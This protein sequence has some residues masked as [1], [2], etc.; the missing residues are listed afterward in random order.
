MSTVPGAPV[1]KLQLRLCPSGTTIRL[2]AEAL[3]QLC[4]A[5][6]VDPALG[7][8]VSA[9]AAEALT[10]CG[11]SGEVEADVRIAAG[12]LV[13]DLH[14]RP[15]V[16]AAWPSACPAGVRAVMDAATATA[17]GDALRLVKRVGGSTA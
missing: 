2:A 5:A 3:A 7:G 11:G 1:F 4:S 12:E 16:G 17:G 14:G 13:F 10:A 6:G 9:A 8:A 15:A